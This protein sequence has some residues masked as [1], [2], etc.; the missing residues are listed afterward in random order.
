MQA[1]RRLLIRAMTHLTYLPA[2]LGAPVPYE[3]QGPLLDRAHTAVNAFSSLVP[4]CESQLAA[5]AR[6]T[7][8]LSLIAQGG[9]QAVDAANTATR[10]DTTSKALKYDVLYR[11]LIKMGTSPEHVIEHLLRLQREVDALHKERQTWVE[12]VQAEPKVRLPYRL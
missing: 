2:I 12:R 3:F 1:H 5:L 7:D 8:S 9:M 4:S 11:K 10:T 6:I